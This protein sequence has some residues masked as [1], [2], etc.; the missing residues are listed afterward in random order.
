MIEAWPGLNGQSWQHLTCRPQKKVKKDLEL[1]A[2]CLCGH[3]H[4]FCS[5]KNSRT[6]SH[7]LKRRRTQRLQ[8]LDRRFVLRFNDRPIRQNCGIKHFVSLRLPE[9]DQPE[10]DRFNAELNVRDL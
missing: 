9:C 7:T 6:L 10:A 5:F 8:P 4:L 2:L 1:F 3:I